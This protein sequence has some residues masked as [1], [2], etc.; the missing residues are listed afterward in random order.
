MNVNYLLPPW[1]I[2]GLVAA[3]LIVKAIHFIFYRNWLVLGLGVPL[4][5][6]LWLYVKEQITVGTIDQPTARFSLALVLLVMLIDRVFNLI[7]ARV[8]RGHKV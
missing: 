7:Y 4:L 1:V 6:T 2:I 5:F 8:R 3:I